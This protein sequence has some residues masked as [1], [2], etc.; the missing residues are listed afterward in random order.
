MPDSTRVT[1][2][3]STALLRKILH[4]PDE[5][6]ILDVERDPYRAVINLLAD[7]PGAPDGAVTMEPVYQRS[8]GWPDPIH[9]CGVQW[10]DEDGN[11]VGRQGGND[12]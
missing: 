12:A 9:L 7:V 6:E 4:L 11:P 1:I 3:I 10:Y 2:P 8:S 5:V